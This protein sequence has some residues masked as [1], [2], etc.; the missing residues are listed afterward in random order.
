M[1]GNLTKNIKK[2]VDSSV[3]NSN[4]EDI[5]KLFEKVKKDFKLI[6]EEY[7]KNKKK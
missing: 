3:T 6:E 1:L 5:K 4:L 7:K 2:I